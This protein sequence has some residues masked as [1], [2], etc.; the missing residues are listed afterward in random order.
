MDARRPTVAPVARSVA[1]T[2]ALLAAAC[3]GDP[4]TV[5][6][7]DLPQIPNMTGRESSGIVHEGNVI[8]AGTFAYKGAVSD[9]D[10]QVA[11]TRAAF[12]G[13]GWTL[14]SERRTPATASLVFAKGVRRARVEVI[15]ND[16]APGMSTA[17][18]RVETLAA[19]PAR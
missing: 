13:R 5:L 6:Q 10:A 4:A 14:E 11:E 15:R 3:S 8:E 16:L 9:L 18:T 12:S 1:L 2:L 17:V 19:A 7:T